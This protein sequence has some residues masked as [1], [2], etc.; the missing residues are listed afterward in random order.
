M[1]IGD[2]AKGGRG[3]QGELAVW[4]GPGGLL[5]PAGRHAGSSMASPP[6][7]LA[8]APFETFE[9][10]RLRF[11]SFSKSA[12]TSSRSEPAPEAIRRWV[13]APAAPP[14]GS[15]LTGEEG[16]GPGQAARDLENAAAELPA[17]KN[18]GDSAQ[19]PHPGTLHWCAH[20]TR[21]VCLWMRV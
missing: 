14:R 8:P 7:G 10:E 15:Q 18:T 9:H 21:R 20:A 3:G 5:P 13:G 12:Q 17:G 19:A 16:H 1:G 2:A 11:Y 6:L 4:A